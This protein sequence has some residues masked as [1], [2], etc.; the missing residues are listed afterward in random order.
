MTERCIRLTID[1]VD[2]DCIFSSSTSTGIKVG[3]G[4]RKFLALH[5]PSGQVRKLIHDFRHLNRALPS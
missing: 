4:L 1:H 3:S 2:A 5:S